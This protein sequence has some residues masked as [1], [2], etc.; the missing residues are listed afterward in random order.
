MDISGKVIAVCP[1]K[2]VTGKNGELIIQEY[3]IET[4]ETYPQKLC[5]SVFG[6]EKIDEFKIKQ[7]DF[8][9][10]ALNFSAR[11]YQGKWFNSISCW[12]VKNQSTERSPEKIPNY[13]KEKKEPERVVNKQPKESETVSNNIDDLPF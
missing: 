13:G 2:K 4:S 6:K 7:G 12:S 5:F 9:S 11:E 10:V 8:V 3:V 1:A